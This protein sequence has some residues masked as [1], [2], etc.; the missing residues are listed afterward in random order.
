MQRILGIDPGSRITG[1][2]VIER[3]GSEARYVTSGTIRTE[4]R[5]FPERLKTIFEQLS[6]LLEQYQPQQAVIE[7]VFMHRNAASALK[8]GQA[9]GAAICACVVAGLPVAEYSPSEVK[10]AI[11]GNGGAGKEQVR[12]MI[13]MLLKLNGR[14]QIDAS[15]ALALALCHSHRA[16]L[17]ARLSTLSGAP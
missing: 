13:A 11:V 7:Q 4:G 14:L 10:Q 2:G 16:A 12:F 5:A 9:R 17:D 15:D 3:A 1:Y 6:T 8:L